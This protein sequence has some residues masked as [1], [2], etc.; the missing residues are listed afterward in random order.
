MSNIG[1]TKL[2]PDEVIQKI[3]HKLEFGSSDYD[4]FN[5]KTKND[6]LLLI[7]SE[8]FDLLCYICDSTNRLTV[9]H[10]KS[11]EDGGTDDPRN[12]LIVC[13]EC[14]D[15]IEDKSIDYINELS[16]RVKIERN[17]LV[18]NEPLVSLSSGE[19]IKY[20]DKDRC[21][22]IW[23]VDSVGVYAREITH[24][25]YATIRKNNGLK[26]QLDTKVSKTILNSAN[27]RMLKINRY[28]VYKT[29]YF[30]VNNDL[31]IN[32]WDESVSTLVRKGLIT[33][34]ESKSRE[35]IEIEFG[36][37]DKMII[38]WRQSGQWPGE[39]KNPKFFK[40]YQIEST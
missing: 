9:H 1:R 2:V 34:N 14:H 17:R 22:K 29:L 25:E 7:A 30:M 19:V 26:D 37:I 32:N 40:Y 12:L 28:T 24:Q 4:I 20:D 6:E 33:K 13:Y 11:R 8:L 3:A 39:K 23:G 16:T 15:H 5:P 38:S 21:Y 18:T 36:T 10:I 27:K 35:F 31:D